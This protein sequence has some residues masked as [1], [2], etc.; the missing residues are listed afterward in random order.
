VNESQALA[1]S[2]DETYQ[3]NVDQHIEHEEEQ[4]E[5]MCFEEMILRDLEGRN[6][7]I[8]MEVSEYAGNLKPE[9]L[10]DWLNAMDKFFEWQPMPKENKVKFACTKLKGHTMIL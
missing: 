3:R 2:D 6:Y 7:R 9:E 10:I 4:L 1:V 5:H 8:K